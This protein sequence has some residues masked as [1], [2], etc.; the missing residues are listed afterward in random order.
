MTPP[1][2]EP[3]NQPATMPSMAV[4]Q[5]LQA[6]AHTTSS[7][8]FR[9]HTSQ[10][11]HRWHQRSG[12]PKACKGA[13]ASINTQRS[14]QAHRFHAQLSLKGGGQCLEQAWGAAWALIWPGALPGVA[15]GA[16]SAVHRSVAAL[17]PA[18]SSSLTARFG[19]AAVTF[20]ALLDVCVRTKDVDRGLDVLDRM[21]AEGVEPDDLTPG[22][23]QNRRVL[24]SYLRKKFL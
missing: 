2:N 1:P 3:A 19:A 18:P 12:V 10:K 9:L 11:P 24:R 23:V 15:R 21:E 6:S 4:S 20:N 7:E 8:P 22:I 5:P 13:A 16:C 17:G 14:I